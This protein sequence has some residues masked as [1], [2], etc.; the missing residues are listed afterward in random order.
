MFFVGFIIG[1]LILPILEGFPLLR[2]L[3]FLEVAQFLMLIYFLF[4]REKGKKT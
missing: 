3:M 1:I 2:T 4:F